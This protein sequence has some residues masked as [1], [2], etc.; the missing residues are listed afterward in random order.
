MMLIRR[1]LAADPQHR[2]C[3]V[4]DRRPG[5]AGI[6]GDDDDAGE[7]EAVSMIGEQLAHQRNHDD[8]RRQVVEQGAEEEGDDADQPH[9]R[10]QF[11][12]TDALGD[13]L[14]TVVRIDHFDDGHG[15]HQEEDDLR[16]CHQRFAQF[17]T[18]LVVVAGRHGVDGPQHAGAEQR[19]CGFVDLERVFQGDR[20]IGDDEYDD[21]CSQHLVTSL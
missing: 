17:V 8:S 21:Q 2:G 12:G 7:K 6:G 13:D 19:R 9:Q 10:R 5:A 4:A 1:D 14:K 15:A 3:Y 11:F 18:D 16:R 20:R